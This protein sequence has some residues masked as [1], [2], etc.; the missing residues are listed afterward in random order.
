MESLSPSDA[1]E[2]LGYP[3]EYSTENPFEAYS[4]EDWELHNS[5][6]TF[7]PE[8]YPIRHQDGAGNYFLEYLDAD[9]VPVKR[10]YLIPKDVA[11]ASGEPLQQRG[12][13]GAPKSEA[14]PPA[15]PHA[16]APP[17]PEV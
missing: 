9:Y 8:H 5:M 10:V 4:E 16:D 6:W 15:P 3:V 12:D 14:Q 2:N 11:D 7:D 13:T 1:N 17:S